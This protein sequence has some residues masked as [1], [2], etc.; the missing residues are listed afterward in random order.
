V[1][2]RRV[3]E[4]VVW[5]LGNE[6]RE[7]VHALFDTSAAAYDFKFRDQVRDAAS[8]VPR[9]VAE[10]FGR[11]RHKE[12]AQFLTIA[13]GSLFEVADHLQDGVLRHYWTQ[14]MIRHHLALCR[15]SIAATTKRIVWLRSHPDP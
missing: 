10:G 8:S 3:E 15:R 14:D 7:Q 12:F 6:L 1:V 2:A 5:Q 9:N 4:L 11:Y 13:R